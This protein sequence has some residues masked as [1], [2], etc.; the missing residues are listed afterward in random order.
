MCVEERK[1]IEAAE[2]EDAIASVNLLPGPA[3]TQRLTRA[4]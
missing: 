2:F 4:S 3:S 1:W